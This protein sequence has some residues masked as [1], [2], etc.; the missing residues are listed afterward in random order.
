MFD[1]RE[2]ELIAVMIFFLFVIQFCEAMIRRE[3]AKKKN[4]TI[5]STETN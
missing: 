3:Y 5:S 1:C 2:A 4:S